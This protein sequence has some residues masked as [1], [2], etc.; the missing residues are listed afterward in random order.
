M[1]VRGG[2]LLAFDPAKGV[3]FVGGY[4]YES[5]SEVPH[6]V[7][8]EKRILIEIEEPQLRVAAI[9]YLDDGEFNGGSVDLD[10]EA[11]CSF[12]REYPAD[13]SRTTFAL[14]FDFKSR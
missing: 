8:D 9:F 11:V 13:G 14:P 5:L 12:Q 6:H 7:L 10:T 4:T 2:E 1:L 3:G